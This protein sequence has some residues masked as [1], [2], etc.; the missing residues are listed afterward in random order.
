MTVELFH[1]PSPRKYGTGPESNSGHLDLQSDSHLLP[2]T[3][4]TVLRGPVFMIA[5]LLI[6]LIIIL[7]HKPGQAEAILFHLRGEKLGAPWFLTAGFN[8]ILK[9]LIDNI[10]KT[11]Q[12]NPHTT[13]ICCRKQ[14]F[15]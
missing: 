5:D 11:S 6:T 9:T 4:P 10:S 14:L 1:D 12:E 2:D 7:I 3:L 13:G 15:S 8:H